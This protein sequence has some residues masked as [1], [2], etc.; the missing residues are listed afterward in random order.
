MIDRNY[1][2]PVAYQAAALGIK[3]RA[4][5]YKAKTPWQ[6]NPN[7][8]ECIRRMKRVFRWYSVRAICD[9]L[10]DRGVKVS[11]YR[12]AKVIRDDEIKCGVPQRHR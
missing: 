9:V 1:P 11:R 10:N 12:V 8:D 2:M 3:R 5:Y 7:R 6:G 4:A